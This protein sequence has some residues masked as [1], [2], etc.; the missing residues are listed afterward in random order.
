MSRFF[1]AETITVGTTPVSL[2]QATLDNVGGPRA[3]RATIQVSLAQVAIAF[4]GD[5]APEDTGVAAV[6]I[7]CGVGE[8][9]E[10][11]GYDN[12]KQVKF[13]SNESGKT[14]SIYIAYEV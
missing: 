9:V 4:T 10:V 12:L 13:V 7:V 8:V 5:P 1:A 6:G 3:G 2:T 14:A 11:D